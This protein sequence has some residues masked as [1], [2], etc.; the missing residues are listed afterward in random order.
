MCSIS[1]WYFG[2]IYMIFWSRKISS[3]FNL[4]HQKLTI[5]CHK[6]MFPCQYCTREGKW[7]RGWWWCWKW[8]QRVHILWWCQ[9]V[10]HD[11]IDLVI[12]KGK[13]LWVW[14]NNWSFNN[15]FY[16]YYHGQ[17]WWVI[18]NYIMSKFLVLFLI[19]EEVTCKRSSI[20]WDKW[21]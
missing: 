8:S 16:F 3:D 2:H 15:P 17:L 1:T 4:S 7:D 12:S 11:W 5:Y 19:I 21:A 18:E 13:L 20:F 6:V 14:I 9:S 10:D